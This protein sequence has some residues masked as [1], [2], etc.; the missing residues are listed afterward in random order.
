L[1]HG[2]QEPEEW[3]PVPGF[4]SLYIASSLG[5][6]ARMIGHRSAR[7]YWAVSLPRKVEGHGCSLG[8]QDKVKRW[9]DRPGFRVY[10]HHIIALA[11]IGPPTKDKPIINHIDGNTDNNRPS[12]LEWCDQRHNVRHAVAFLKPKRRRGRNLTNEEIMWIKEQHKAGRS[13]NSIAKEM[14]MHSTSVSYWV[15]MNRLGVRNG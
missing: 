8:S 6:V 13:M 5:R 7:R 2:P 12:N 10:I 1:E 11:F 4:E 15:R 3:R 9:G 14:N